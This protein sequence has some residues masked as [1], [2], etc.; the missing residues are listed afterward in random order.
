M[1]IYLSCFVSAMSRGSDRM[2]VG[3]SARY[4]FNF[5]HWLPMQSLLTTTTLIYA[6]RIIL[7]NSAGRSVFR[8]A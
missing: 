6:C 1:K 2:V 3:F 4:V 5:S 7:L 8:A